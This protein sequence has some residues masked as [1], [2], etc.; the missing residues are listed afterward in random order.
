MSLTIFEMPGLKIK[1]EVTEGKVNLYPQGKLSPLGK[2]V[3]TP[4]N[5]YFG[6]ER[7]LKYTDD[8]IIISGWIPPLPSP[9]FT[10]LLKSEVI[11]KMT[12]KRVPQQVSIA[13]TG[14]CPCDCIFCCAKGIETK[15]ELTLD[16]I[17]SI[18]DQA[19]KMGSHLITF[20]GGEPLLREDIYDIISYA[21]HTLA[22]TVLF[23]NGL[24]LAKEVAYKLKKAG[25]DTL[26]VSIDSPYQEEHNQIRTVP[27]IFEKATQGVKYAVEAGLITSIFYVA[28]PENSDFKTLYDL[29]D[30]GKRLGAHEISIYDILAIGRWLTYEAETLTDEDRARTI[31]LHKEANLPGKEGPK[32]MAFSYLEGIQRFGCMG[33][34]KWIHFTPAGD[35]IPCSYTP[36]SFGNIRE[37]SLKDIW[38]NMQAHPEI[39][40]DCRPCMVQDKDFRKKYIY[41]IPEG[42]RLPY[43]IH[44]IKSACTV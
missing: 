23:T 12:G 35:G 18:I 28:R 44:K 5:E 29:L 1:A 7:P 2:I 32:I 15:P 20:D 14:R 40:S 16:E 26:Q 10:R 39:K 25:L 22:T 6:G 33:G 34:R 3:T 13:V 36:L 19:I 17:K 31:A 21:S 38:K 11:S 9:A 24:Y 8:E 37:Y 41:P 27:G 4:I 30:L 42:A 43:P